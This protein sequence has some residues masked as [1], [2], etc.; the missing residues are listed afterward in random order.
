MQIS[1]G[2]T[3]Y[4]EEKNISKLLDRLLKE[5]FSFIL[6]EIIVVASGC[7]DRTKDIVK[8]FTK[9]NKKIIL[10]VEKKRRGKASAINIIFKKAESDIM[11]FI[12]A[13]DIPTK[14]SINKLIEPFKKNDVFTTTGRM[15]PK[16]DGSRLIDFLNYFIWELHHQ[17]S[18]NQPKISGQFFAIK[19]HL[20]RKV[21]EKAICDDAFIE[22]IL[23]KNNI[24]TVYV[25]EATI[26]IET[27]TT[28]SNFWKQRRRIAAGYIQLK[29]MNL[30]AAYSLSQIMKAL[31]K[32]IIKKPNSLH[33]IIFAIFLEIFTN[34]FAF[35]DILRKNIQYCWER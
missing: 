12:D 6:R 2:I 9:I 30:N 27:P 10:I 17:V 14:N 19:R 3:A 23:R 26:Y 21:Y 18:I 33:K 5:K 15:V 29:L 25:P 7:T 34:I 28:I 1:I 8:E 4:N 20:I 13:D 16:I 22:G 31:M 32:K 24:K 11:V 35:Y